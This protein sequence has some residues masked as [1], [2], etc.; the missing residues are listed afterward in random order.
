MS[1]YILNLGS[2]K[3]YNITPASSIYL[4]AT[5]IINIIARVNY[6]S[7]FLYN[8][9]VNK[10]ILTLFVSINK[11]FYFWIISSIHKEKCYHILKINCN[12][13]W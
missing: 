10:L 8:F 6:S 12:K 9:N 13:G 2:S 5:L 11:Y 1:W 3:A 4:E 7:I